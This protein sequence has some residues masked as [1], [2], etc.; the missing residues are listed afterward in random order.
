[1]PLF[2]STASLVHAAE[3]NQTLSEVR[4]VPEG[5]ETNQAPKASAW[6]LGWRLISRCTPSAS[7]HVFLERLRPRALLGINVSCMKQF[8]NVD[9]RQ[10]PTKQEPLNFV[11]TLFGN[12][13][14]EL[15]VSLDALDHDAES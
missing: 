4:E 3:S 11:D 15:F 13:Q 7:R 10:W 1:M 14:F 2:G 5:D 12:K 8:T 9:C 6:L